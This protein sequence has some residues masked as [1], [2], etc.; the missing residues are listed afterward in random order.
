MDRFDEEAKKIADAQQSIPSPTTEVSEAFAA[1][2]RALVADLESKLAAETN[3]YIAQNADIWGA[4]AKAE[5][6]RKEAEAKLTECK[7]EL[8]AQAIDPNSREN[9]CQENAMLR[10]DLELAQKRVKELEAEGRAPDAR[11]REALGIVSSSAD[12]CMLSHGENLCCIRE[13]GLVSIAEEALSPEPE[14]A[15]PEVKP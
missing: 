2:G 14:K 7:K 3:N 6:Q 8:A 1:W 11:M 10:N 4:L 12:D 5:S 13:A 9:L 15:A